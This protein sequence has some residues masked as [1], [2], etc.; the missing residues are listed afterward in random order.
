MGLNTKILAI[1]IQKGG[2]GKTAIAVNLSYL[3][4]EDSYPVAGR[5][6]ARKPLK[7][8]LIDLDPQ[9]NSSHTLLMHNKQEEVEFPVGQTS[10]AFFGWSMDSDDS[11]SWDMDLPF[12][13]AIPVSPVFGQ[14]Y[15]GK[16]KCIPGHSLALADADALDP[17]LVFDVAQRIRDYA[18]QSDDDVIIIDCSPQL[19]VRQIVAMLAADHIV[20]PINS[21]AYSEKGLDKFVATFLQVQES[22]ED[23]KLHIIPNKVDSKSNDNLVNLDLLREKIGEWMTDSNIPYSNSISKALDVGRPPWRKAPSGNDALI[24]RQ[25]RAALTELLARC[26][27]VAE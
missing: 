14:F 3:L 13:A 23:C 11:L 12:P 16:I 18:L 7:V 26:E 6:T 8:T 24:G 19:G 9:C 15:D 20:T 25:V 4:A 27:I 21:D 17:E 10:A 2:V 22:N 1:A 5:P